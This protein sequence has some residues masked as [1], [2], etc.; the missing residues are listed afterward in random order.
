MYIL[1]VIQALPEYLGFGTP[2]DSLASCYGLVPKAPRKDIVKYL[3]YA[4]K[5]LRFECT[6]QNNII[7]DQ[8][9][10][11]ILKYS[12]A[13]GTL[14]I[15][16]TA[17]RNSG[18]NGGRFLSSQKVIKPGGNPDVPEYYTAKDLY[19][20]KHPKYRNLIARHILY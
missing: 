19:L 11:F 20:G 8:Q 4:N 10:H 12:L 17:I 3:L 14:S 18:I 1:F 13:D 6:L 7:E 9:R 15:Y 16:E 5:H 2:E